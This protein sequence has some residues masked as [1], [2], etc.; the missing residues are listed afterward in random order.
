MEFGEHAELAAH[1]ALLGVFQRRLILF[2][3]LLEEEGARVLPYI[4]LPKDLDI[5]EV[6]MEEIEVSGPRRARSSPR[7]SCTPEPHSAD[8]VD[9]VSRKY[10]AKEAQ[11]ELEASSGSLGSRAAWE[12]TWSARASPL[13]VASSQ[14]AV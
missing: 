3:R 7:A 6:E 10:A 13:C 2:W 11:R 1:K 14:A 9:Q 5:I 12:T 8:F 4:L